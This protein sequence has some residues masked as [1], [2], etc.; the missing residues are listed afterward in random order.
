MIK[1]TYLLY[2]SYEIKAYLILGTKSYIHF[3]HVLMV[4]YKLSGDFREAH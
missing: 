2:P 4:P 3:V 1:S